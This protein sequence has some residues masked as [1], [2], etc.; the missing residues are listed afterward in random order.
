MIMAFVVCTF[1]SFGQPVLESPTGSRCDRHPADPVLPVVSPVGIDGPRA[2]SS[3]SPP[4]SARVLVGA[5]L[6]S[7]RIVVVGRPHHLAGLG[8][9]AL[10]GVADVVE[11]AGLA[12]DGVVS[13]KS[14][15]VTWPAGWRV[16]G[17]GPRERSSPDRSS[18]V[19]A[20]CSWRSCLSFLPMS[21]RIVETLRT[22]SYPKGCQATPPCPGPMA[23]LSGAADPCPW[24]A[25][26]PAASA[27]A[28]SLPR[29]A[30]RRRA[31]TRP[32][33]A[34]AREWD[35]VHGGGRHHPRRAPPHPR[36]APRAS[37]GC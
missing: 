27:G 8:G 28:P 3:W 1:I 17:V 32:R 18:R 29:A 36:R 11:A 2:L 19:G 23:R 22:G 16:F 26:P 15:P 9:R 6:A 13:A 20:S 31:L 21:P 10:G 35:A 7:G 30:R 34:G 5:G 37:G 33:G 14:R 25:G 4:T 12:G 24:A